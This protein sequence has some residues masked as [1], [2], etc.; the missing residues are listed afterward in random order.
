MASLVSVQAVS[1]QDRAHGA[2]WAQSDLEVGQ[3]LRRGR[4]EGK[5]SPEGREEL[6]ENSEIRT[7]N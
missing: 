6:R 5:A 4:R 3:E 1:Q 7:K 2:G